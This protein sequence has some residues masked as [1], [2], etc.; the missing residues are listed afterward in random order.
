MLGEA[1]A[2]FKKELKTPS[3]KSIML[4]QC[5]AMLTSAGRKSEARRMLS[6]LEEMFRR[7]Y[8]PAYEVALI[9]VGLGD[10]DQH[11]PCWRRPKRSVSS[12]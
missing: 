5:S 3:R 2:L 6:K 7:T 10:T 12:R 4:T 8:V 9:H 1:I 11:S